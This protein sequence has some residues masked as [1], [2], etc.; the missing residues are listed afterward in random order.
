MSTVSTTE[1]KARMGH[2]DETSLKQLLSS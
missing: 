1:G 2:G